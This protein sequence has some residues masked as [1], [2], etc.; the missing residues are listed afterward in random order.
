[1][2]ENHV[3]LDFSQ[4]EIPGRIL[5]GPPRMKETMETV[6]S[7]G[8]MPVVEKIIMQESAADQ[9]PFVQA[10]TQPG[11]QNSGDADTGAGSGD[12]MSEDR[13]SA[14]LQEVFLRLHAGGKEY[15]GSMF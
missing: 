14:V 13:D 10:D 5:E 11:P 3:T 12:G 15:V 2:A 1:M 6:G 8:N 7:V 9:S 4:G